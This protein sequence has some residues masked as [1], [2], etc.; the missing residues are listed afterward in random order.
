MNKASPRLTSVG[1]Y[2]AHR[3]AE[4]G[5]GS[6]FGVP[7]D[8]NLGILDAITS[9][10]HMDWVGTA[11][12]HGAGYAADGYA[13]LKGLGAIVTTFGVGELSAM[14]AIAGAYAE[15][16]PVVH[17]VG[18]PAR[19][20]S[21]NGGLFH[22]NL[23]GPGFGHFGR[24]AAEVTAS[25][26]DLRVGTAPQQIDHSIRTAM[27]TSLPVYITVPADVAEMP[28]PWPEAP[29]RFDRYA[30]DR[31]PSAL[32]DF[33]V[34]AC[35]LVA[36]A[37][38][39]GVLLGHLAARHG[40]TG[41]IEELV[42]AGDLMLAVLS[43]AKGDFPEDDPHFAGLYAGAAS[44]KR[45]RTTVEDSDVLV[46]VGVTLV[47]SLTGGGAHRLPQIGRMDLGP[48]GAKIGERIYPGVGLRHSL[49]AVAAV[50]RE[51]RRTSVSSPPPSRPTNDRR[52]NPQAPLTQPDLWSSVQRLL[53]PGDLIFADQG[54]AFHGAAGL[55]LPSGARLLAQPLWAS[56]GWA[57][58]AALG[59]T[60]AAPE[61]RVL[62]VVGDGA[63]QQS[64]SELSKLL[65]LGRR[66][67]VVVINNDGYT[68]ERAFHRPA[69]A[70]HDIPPWRWTLLPAMVAPSSSTH[71]VR[72]ASPHSLEQALTAARHNPKGPVL[73]EAVLA[74]GDIPPLLA[75]LARD[76]SPGERPTVDGGPKWGA[77]HSAEG[78]ATRNSAD[79]DVS[80]APAFFI[81]GQS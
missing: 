19:A 68:N 36:S 65:T 66:P 76:V 58:P 50:F 71:A 60:L 31:D 41:E 3:L 35:H 2:L 43:T 10:P 64:A 80:G 51:L 79:V 34:D 73:V 9:Q 55:S 47:D 23:P 28:V 38:S 75:Q 37:T 29:L 5:I 72:A 70:Y 27:R 78:A 11:T 59:A 17:I 67:V 39:A 8:Y 12:E 16:V 15:S 63:L 30:D 25:Q 45:A 61:R 53:Q 18:T 57:V 33:A 32:F 26:T 77:V 13:R 22:H 42:D 49:A 24:M 44:D 46:T 14:N 48:S 7:G 62:V 21:T 54:T 74:P 69:A 4:C 6:V 40:V 52:T 81:A 20:A 1:R 56:T